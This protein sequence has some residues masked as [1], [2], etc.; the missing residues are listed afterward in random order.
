MQELDTYT[1]KVSSKRK[2]LPTSVLLT[3]A[4]FGYEY[5]NSN[6][7]LTR[8]NLN[9][10]SG[11]DTI[12]TPSRHADEKE[13]TI[14]DFPYGGSLTVYFAFDSNY[15]DTITARNKYVDQDRIHPQNVALKV[16]VQCVDANTGAVIL[17]KQ[18]HEWEILA[19]KVP[20]G[21]TPVINLLIAKVTIQPINK[22]F[23]IKLVKP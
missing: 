20:P 14:T 12:R 21:D 15:F 18:K 5:M 23:K 8:V 1:I 2:I 16:G 7:R 4:V 11:G 19:K 9:Y 3:N 10:N 22:P 17:T 6:D 13:T